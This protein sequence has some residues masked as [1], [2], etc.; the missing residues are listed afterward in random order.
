MEAGL[1]N[2]A[3]SEP[4]ATASD[5]PADLLDLEASSASHGHVLHMFTYLRIIEILF[6]PIT[7][8][9]FN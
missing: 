8:L 9:S 1:G 4:K 5:V 3:D 6:A 7:R 2:T